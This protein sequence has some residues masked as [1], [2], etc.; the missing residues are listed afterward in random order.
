M[1]IAIFTL[2]NEKFALETKIVNSIEKMMNIT[3]VP[4]APYYI[5][6]LINLRG[7]IASVVDLK[8][9]LNMERVRDEE[10]IIIVEIRDEKIGFMVDEVIEVVEVTE[11]MIEK[12]SDSLPHI[13]GIINLPDYLVTLLD[14]DMLLK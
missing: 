11:D 6:G 5:K 1:Q 14:S 7:T 4:T 10:S 9:Y 8:S 2:G 13:R 3:K 12:T